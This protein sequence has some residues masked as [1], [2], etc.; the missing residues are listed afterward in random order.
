MEDIQ[1]HLAL[2][3][4]PGIGSVQN[5]LLLQHFTTAAN[6]FKAKRK[7]ISAVEGI[8]DVRAKAIKAFTDYK[9][10]E[11]EIKFCAKHHIQILIPSSTIYPQ[12]LLN[13]YDP[14]PVLFYR[15]TADL[16]QQKTVSIIGTRNNTAYGKTVTEE[17]IASLQEQNVLVLSG[18][19]YGID[20][21]AHKAALKN[22]IP[23]VGVL[24]HGLDTIYPASHTSLAKEMLANGGL[25]T[26]FWKGNLPAKHNFPKRNRIVAGMS[27]AI[28]VIETAAKGG[29]MI[30]AEIAYG[31]NRDIFALPGRIND[32]KSAG[33]LK[34]IEQNKAI[35]YTSATQFIEAMGWKPKA[36]NTV[37]QRSLFIELSNEENIIISLLEKQASMGIDEIYI[38]SGLSSSRTAAAILNLELQ[39]LLHVLPG[40]LY[41]LT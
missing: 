2:C 25:L 12:R 17:L 38:K 3:M 10:V 5:R 16:N 20:A 24:A 39:G 33:C 22:N 28:I 27:D 26:E 29:S 21:I 34:L 41:S 23:T 13:C 31:Y 8:G 40:K 36:A 4:V 32:A 18:L 9:I 1:N 30:T 7:E 14:P 19:A 11:D 35:L 15:G 6:V 37:K